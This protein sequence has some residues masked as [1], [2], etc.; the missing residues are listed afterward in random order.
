MPY[1]NEEALLPLPQTL[2]DGFCRG[3]SL[4]QEVITDTIDIEEVEDE[5]PPPV[6]DSP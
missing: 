2:A 3:L 1:Y 5:V 4:F 6:Y